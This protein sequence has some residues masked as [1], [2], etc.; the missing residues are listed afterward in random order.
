MTQMANVATVF[1]VLLMIGGV[2]SLAVLV[3]GNSAR[4]WLGELVGTVVGVGAFFALC[5]AFGLFCVLILMSLGAV[6]AGVLSLF[7]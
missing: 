4:T 5:G 7:A 1:A 6:V 3:I 2:L